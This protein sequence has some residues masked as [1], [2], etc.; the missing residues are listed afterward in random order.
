M[1]GENVW[2]SFP[3]ALPFQNFLGLR[4]LDGHT[5]KQGLDGGVGRRAEAR[6][7]GLRWKLSQKPDVFYEP[8]PFALSGLF[9]Y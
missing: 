3:L 9:L 1:R 5:G 6:E 2:K 8:S 7:P 4:S